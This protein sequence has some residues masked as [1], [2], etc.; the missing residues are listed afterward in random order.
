M[1]NKALLLL[2]LLA[3]LSIAGCAARAGYSYGYVSVPPPAARVEV[4]GYAPGPG[5]AWVNRYWNWRG[6]R[7]V[8]VP[9]SWQRPPRPRAR[10]EPGRWEN[11]HGRYAFRQ[12]R[13]R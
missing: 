9:G 2:P 12:G 5:F 7:Y 1:K 8:W 11:H 4:Y 13:W 10:W 6:S 3:G